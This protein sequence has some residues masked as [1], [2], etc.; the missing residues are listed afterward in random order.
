MNL[1]PKKKNRWI[2]Q[3]KNCGVLSN[4]NHI[5]AT[6]LL[7]FGVR[8]FFMISTFILRST[9]F[10][11]HLLFIQRP[12]RQRPNT[13]KLFNLCVKTMTNTMNVYRG[14]LRSLNRPCWTWMLE[15]YYSLL[16]AN[17]YF[18]FD[19][20]PLGMRYLKYFPKIFD[21]PNA[22]CATPF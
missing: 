20:Y 19:Y 22:I 1:C 11:F 17:S 2:Y 6:L 10:H 7:L 18:Q 15:Y 5:S 21:D 14:C 9:S 4:K 13:S 8:P 12:N 3:K 16:L